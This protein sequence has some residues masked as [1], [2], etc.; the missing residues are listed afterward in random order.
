MEPVQTRRTGLGILWGLAAGWSASAV[1]TGHRGT[2]VFAVVLV[3]VA[4]T[5]TLLAP[6]WRLDA[7]G[8][9]LHRPVGAGR[10]VTWSSIIAL[11]YHSTEHTARPQVG[12]ARLVVDGEAPLAV[13]PV[14]VDSS[15]TLMDHL[16]PALDARDVPVEGT[17]PAT[18]KRRVVV[19]AALVVTVVVLL[20]ST[21]LAVTTGAGIS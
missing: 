6:R 17:P 19:L 14:K 21:L 16:L 13:G 2:A 18:P 11:R 15:A 5:A 20:G 12:Q 1:L 10:D 4:V 7:A 3:I 8:V 9:H